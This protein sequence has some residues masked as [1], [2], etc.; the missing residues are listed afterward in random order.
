MP[1]ISLP[2]PNEFRKSFIEFFNVF[3]RQSHFRPLE[4]CLSFHHSAKTVPP[5]V[6]NDRYDTKFNT[7]FKILILFDME[8]AFDT[9]VYSFLLETFI[10]SNV[11]D[12]HILSFSSAL[13]K[14]L[15]KFLL[16]LYPSVK[17]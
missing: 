4:C 12:I 8:T 7:T 10:C 9:D 5:R 15:S 3:G 13:L 14:F 17:C 2:F 16:H 1:I 6:N 11:L